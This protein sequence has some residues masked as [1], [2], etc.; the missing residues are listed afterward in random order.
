[1]AFG[2]QTFNGLALRLK[3]V[4][5]ANPEKPQR[6]TEPKEPERNRRRATGGNLAAHK[7]AVKGSAMRN[8][9]NLWGMTDLDWSE[10]TD[11]F[12]K[13]LT[14][15]AALKLWK[16]S[17]HCRTQQY[18]SSVRSPADAPS[19]RSRTNP[20]RGYSTTSPNTSTS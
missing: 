6:T 15:I 19:V 12:R 2:G 11:E 17:K 1:M 7:E 13:L 16:E 14:L 20:C 3:I 5:A 9:R 4:D 10:E 8:F 18:L